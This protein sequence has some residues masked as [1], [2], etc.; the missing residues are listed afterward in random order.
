MNIKG[1][2][3]VFVIVKAGKR[4]DGS[5][6]GKQSPPLVDTR[7]TRGVT[8]FWG[9]LGTQRK[10]EE[11][12]LIQE[13][14]LTDCTVGAV[15]GQLAAVQRVA[16]SIRARS[17]S[18]CDPQIFVSGLD[19]LKGPSKYRC[20]RVPA[21]HSYFMSKMLQITSSPLNSTIRPSY[22]NMSQPY[23]RYKLAINMPLTCKPF[24]SESGNTALFLEAQLSPFPIFSIPDSQT[25]L[26]VLVTSLVLGCP[27]AAPI[28]YHQDTY[29]EH[30]GLKEPSEIKGPSWAGARYGAAEDRVAVAS[31]RKA[32]IGTGH[33]S[34][35]IN[36]YLLQ[37]CDDDPGSPAG[38]GPL[39]RREPTLRP[40]NCL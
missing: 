7:N 21:V 28:T 24:R 18:L 32:R 13:S 29:P 15:A 12:G 11:F 30:T 17:N 8:S 3:R 23:A 40:A 20:E 9:R 22:K 38:Y 36:A 16:G 19:V 34:N 25:T 5:P 31:A 10:R 6:D 35:G 37:G 1:V 39:C 33:R 14:D 26:N 2:M 4:A 27:W